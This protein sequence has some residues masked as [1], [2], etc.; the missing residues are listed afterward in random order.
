M[1]AKS[2]DAFSRLLQMKSTFT[3][4][5]ISAADI[6]RPG[7]CARGASRREDARHERGRNMTRVSRRH[8]DERE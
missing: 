6:E 5:L 8:A 3:L 1:F 7:A 4:R 2:F